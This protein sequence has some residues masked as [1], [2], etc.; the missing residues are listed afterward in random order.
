M[1]IAA[2]KAVVALVFSS[3]VGTG[4]ATVVDTDI[5]IYG[6]NSGAIAAA[7]QAKRK[8][9][10]V[11]LAVFNT[12]L[13]GLTSGGLGATDVGNVGSIG[14][15]SREF[16][17]RIG[18]R[19]GQSERFNFEPHIAREVYEQWLAELGITPRWNQ[20][21]ASVTKSGERLQRITMEDGTIY[22]ARMFI[23]ASYEGDLM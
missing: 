4:R 21:L 16:Y 18:Q 10:T 22:Q 13:G 6:G 1:R 19:Y 2:M 11:S 3:I 17:R 14:G 15:V 7:V 8:G 20:R 23:D 5:C 12:H 9:K